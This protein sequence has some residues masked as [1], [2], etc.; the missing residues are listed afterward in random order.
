[1]IIHHNPQDKFSRELIKQIEG[2]NLEIIIQGSN[3]IKC[4]VAPAIFYKND[5]SFLVINKNNFDIIIENLKKNNIL[6]I[7][8]MIKKDPEFHKV[9]VFTKDF[10][11]E[12]LE[13][14][15]FNNINSLYSFHIEYNMKK[16]LE[17][18]QSFWIYPKD[19]S[20]NYIHPERDQQ[21]I[22]ANTYL[23]DFGTKN[24]KD[25][26][27][28]NGMYWPLI[29]YK[30]NN[31]FVVYEG[32][33]RAKAIKDI[34]RK[35]LFISQTILNKEFPLSSLYTITNENHLHMQK[36]YFYNPDDFLAKFAIVNAQI[37]NM[38]FKEKKI[39][40]PY[41]SINNENDFKHIFEKKFI[42]NN[43]NEY[44]LP[45]EAI[46]DIYNIYYKHNLKSY[47]NKMK[48]LNIND[49]NIEN[50]D[51]KN[52]KGLKSLDPFLKKHNI[53]SLGE[54]ILKNGMYW[55]FIV[56]L[57]NNK[58][59]VAEGYHRYQALKSMNVNLKI[60]CIIED[61]QCIFKDNVNNSCDYSEE[62][63]IPK[64]IFP[65]NPFPYKTY[66]IV[67]SSEYI[68]KIVVHN[69]TQK[70]QAYKLIPMIFKHLA[71]YLENRYGEEIEKIN[72]IEL[73]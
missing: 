35:F 2:L 45:K 24:L 41:Y 69:N 28:K 18:F 27:K 58:Y 30:E 16:I 72:F 46:S 49:L 11:P 57:K 7:K 47:N 64:N 25:S 8:E 54:D 22:H 9:D 63:Y 44:T 61:Q 39:I 31:K 62:I 26:I 52:W 50:I 3:L 55:P 68:N 32:T 71:I 53:K 15:D 20:I 73:L 21:N 59:Y 14:K 4:P 36:M 10:G 56:Y 51:I 13:T 12:G 66:D 42:L 17:L 48:W 1:M 60:Q 70:I 38:I 43:I 34:N 40:Q 19:I 67:D 5:K 37:S 65:Y 33:H 6:K 23:R 29:G